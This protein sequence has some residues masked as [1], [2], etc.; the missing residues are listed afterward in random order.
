L[1]KVR[2]CYANESSESDFSGLGV[3][4]RGV[5]DTLHDPRKRIWGEVYGDYRVF[6]GGYKLADG[7]F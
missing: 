6:V 3:D 1:K 7:H 4:L 2:R 5:L